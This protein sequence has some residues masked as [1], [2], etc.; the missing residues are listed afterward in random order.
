M[1]KQCES[2]GAEH[3]PNC[4][5]L[6]GSTGCNC[7]GVELTTIDFHGRK[8]TL[9]SVCLAKEKQALA[10]ADKV[11]LESFENTAHYRIEQIVTK[12]IKEQCTV[13]H[14]QEIYAT[15]RP[16]WIVSNFSSVDELKSKLVEF[17]T[18]MEKLEWECRAKKRAAFD[19]AK[20]ME[21]RLSKEERDALLFDPNFKV[22]TNSEFKKIAKERELDEAM[23]TLG[24]EKDKNKRKAVEGLLKAGMT[25][26][27]IKEMIK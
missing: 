10:Q 23:K 18:S 21:A 24:V 5:A 26:E 17:I 13:A 1:H 6:L 9:C 22:P 3:T 14:W 7:T 8:L 27:Q 2:C 20:E 11:A 12:N 15:E 16:H 25:V 4:I 19:A